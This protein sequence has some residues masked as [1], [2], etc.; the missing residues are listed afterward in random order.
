MKLVGLVSLLLGLVVDQGNEF[1]DLDEFF[2]GLLVLALLL[3]CA[4]HVLQEDHPQIHEEVGEGSFSLKE[5]QIHSEMQVLN[6]FEV[7]KQVGDDLLHVLGLL[8]RF[9]ESFGIVMY[10]VFLIEVNLQQV[11]FQ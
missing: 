10:Q 4:S 6:V 8:N 1:L 2:F 7:I 11:L 9:C 3:H 5:D